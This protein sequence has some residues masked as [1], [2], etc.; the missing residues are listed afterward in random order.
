MLMCT[1]GVSRKINIM[2]LVRVQIEKIDAI[3]RI[4]SDKLI[5]HLNQDTYAVNKLTCKPPLKTP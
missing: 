3:A 4:G 2:T 5:A 1:P